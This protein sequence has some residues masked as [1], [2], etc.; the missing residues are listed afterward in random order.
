[1]AKSEYSATS[2]ISI[3]SPKSDYEEDDEIL[4]ALDKYLDFNDDK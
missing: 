2:E 1:M 3:A 4:R